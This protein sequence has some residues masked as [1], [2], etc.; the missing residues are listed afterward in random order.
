MDP[1]SSPGPNSPVDLVFLRHSGSPAALA[2]RVLLVQ[3][4][5]L[6][7]MWGIPAGAL[8][9]LTGVERSNFTRLL[10]YGLSIVAVIAGAL[11]LWTDL[12][13]VCRIQILPDPA[14][15][16]LR[17]SWLGR[18]EESP[19]TALREV[20]ITDFVTLPRPGDRLPA[21]SDGVEV[22]LDVS[23]RQVQTQRRIRTDPQAL[24]DA[25]SEVLTPLDIAVRRETD[26]SVRRRPREGAGGAG[27]AAGGG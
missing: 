10:L 21:T 12:G 25:L 23:G 7:L 20:V 15:G 17:V 14:P 11:W 13:Q 1:V 2:R 27:G 4:P 6:V 8:Y 18:A 22:R 16:R 26:R 9:S 24:A 19:L 5:V 3:V